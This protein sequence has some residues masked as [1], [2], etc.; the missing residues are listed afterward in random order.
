MYLH[1]KSSPE[2]ICDGVAFENYG[3]GEQDAADDHADGPCQW[4]FLIH[5]KSYDTWQQTEGQS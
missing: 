5:N 1:I 2:F 4:H 3:S